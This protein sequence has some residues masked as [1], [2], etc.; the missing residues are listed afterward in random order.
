MGNTLVGHDVVKSAAAFIEA[1]EKNSKSKNIQVGVYNLKKQMSGAQAVAALL[2]AKNRVVRGATIPEGLTY[3]ETFQKLSEATKI[4]VDQFKEAAKDPIGLGVPDWWFN[5]SDKKQAKKDNIEGFL[6]PATYEFPPNADATTV[7]RT[8]ISHFNQEMEKLGFVDKV[9]KER[10]GI[11][12]YEALIAAS[13]AQREAAHNE[14]MGP[15]ARVLYNR[16]YTGK[17]PCNCLQIDSA[18]NYWLSITGKGGKASE[19]LKDSELHDKSNPYNTHDFAGFPIGPIGNPGEAALKGAMEPPPSDY[20][21]F[22]TIDNNKG[23]MAYAKTNA[24]FEQK[25]QIACQNGVQ[26]CNIK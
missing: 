13:I 12:P 14:D 22:V 3:L 11:S 16:V 25:K 7:L 23:T 2:D 1:A 6:Y 24:E 5:R 10:G 18:V 19:K 17:F 4:P 21:F 8:M 20:F 9:Q 15:V 26:I